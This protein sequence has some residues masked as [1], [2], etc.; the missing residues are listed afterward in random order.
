MI[1]A[2]GGDGD[3]GGGHVDRDCSDFPNQPAAQAYFDQNGGSPTNNFDGLDADH[4]GIACENLPQN[5]PEGGLVD[6]QV[7]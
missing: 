5:K 1:A 6:G 3:S 2:C 4:D 7:Q